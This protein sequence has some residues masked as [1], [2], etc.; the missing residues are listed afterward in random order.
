MQEY[1]WGGKGGVR[2]RCPHFSAPDTTQAL[3]A[4]RS[5]RK[6]PAA[7]AS[8][9]FAGKHPVLRKVYGQPSAKYQDFRIHFQSRDNLHSR[10]RLKERQRLRRNIR[11]FRRH[12]RQAAPAPG[13][14]R[15]GPPSL[16]A[17]ICRSLRALRAAQNPR[18][19]KQAGSRRLSD[20]GLPGYDTHVHYE[21]DYI[22]QS[23]R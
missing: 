16:R 14:L 2:G 1:C 9:A 17:R 7:A 10:A 20:A 19:L 5:E 22:P 12:S 21:T 11:R 18:S 13:R 4:V 3:P 8:A 23:K 15:S 6:A